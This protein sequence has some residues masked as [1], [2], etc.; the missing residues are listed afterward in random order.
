MQAFSKKKVAV[1]LAVALTAGVGSAWA[2]THG[3]VT[4]AP[5]YGVIKN[6]TSKLYV[7]IGQVASFVE[8][9]ASGG[10]NV[11]NANANGKTIDL[12]LGNARWASDSVNTV[13]NAPQAVL[14]IQALGTAAV[15]F[16]FVGGTGASQCEIAFSTA[17][18]GGDL[19]SAYN[20]TRPDI[21]TLQIAAGT[22]ADAEPLQQLNV[23]FTKLMMAGV[24]DITVYN[25]AHAY[26]DST[27]DARPRIIDIT[28]S[29]VGA[30]TLTAQQGPINGLPGV[31]SDNSPTLINIVAPDVTINTVGSPT[32]YSPGRIIPIP[33]FT[34]LENAANAL[35]CDAAGVVS[36]AP[37]ITLTLPEGLSF[38]TLNSSATPIVTRNTTLTMGLVDVTVSATAPNVLYEKC[39]TFSTDLGPNSAAPFATPY[40]GAQVQTYNSTSFTIMIAN[41]TDFRGD[42]TG[43]LTVLLS[44]NS[45]RTK[46]V[47][48]ATVNNR[49]LAGALVDN[50]PVGLQTVFTGRTYGLDLAGQV[51]NPA[52]FDQFRVTETAVATI[53]MTANGTTPIFAVE[54]MNARQNVIA[55]YSPNASGVYAL[56][57]LADKWAF[58][59]VGS[60]LSQWRVND[61]TPRDTSVGANVSTTIVGGHVFTFPGLT[62]GWQVGTVDARG[63]VNSGEITSPNTTILNV[64]DATTF[65]TVGALPRIAQ[66]QSQFGPSM[67]LTENFAGALQTEKGLPGV[68]SFDLLGTLSSDVPGKWVVGA[69]TTT[70][71]WCGQPVPAAN[72]TLNQG[73]PDVAPG[74]RLMV[75]LPSISTDAP[76]TLQVEPFIYSQKNAQPGQP[77]NVAVYDPNDPLQIQLYTSRPAPTQAWAS[78]TDIQNWAQPTASPINKEA[79]RQLGQI[80]G[81]AQTPVSAVV[82]GTPDNLTLTCQFQ[83]PQ[84]VQG[85]V[86]TIYVAAMLPD[87]SAFFFMDSTGAWH[88]YFQGDWAPYFAG[89]MDTAPYKIAVANGLDVTGLPNGTQILV[90]WGNNPTD[91]ATNNQYGT[92]YTVSY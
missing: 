55:T 11:F 45:T 86:K 68:V 14:A 62:I 37:T 32:T 31:E 16:S 91:V 56:S 8:N 3:N 88:Q 71:T 80:E 43:T 76:C 73:A 59:A 26:A 36:T 44:D 83:A 34:V 64:L 17:V 92:C 29:A 67:L 46:T 48:L 24:S 82:S 66:D 52:I 84:G 77:I 87:L 4:K 22:C 10:N 1:A 49:G 25:P 70:A 85:T 12:V 53:P 47:T 60:T 28:N 74:G 5:A 20:G 21:I 39:R 19:A 89:T 57:T 75:Q 90:G 54:T 81:G 79:I 78:L 69:G 27:F 23:D 51:R 41:E 2:N 38:G 40:Q 65:K 7:E 50:D 61:G 30:V 63:S 18:W 13:G 42:I 35:G 33:A 58:P 15:Y 6:T 72:L 9:N